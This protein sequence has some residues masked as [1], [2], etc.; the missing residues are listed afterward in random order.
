MGDP[1]PPS[2]PSQLAQFIDVLPPDKQDMLL[3]AVDNSKAG[4]S[5]MLMRYGIGGVVG[6]VLGVVVAKVALR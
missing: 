3:D 5:R 2:D 4:H 1:V 6:L